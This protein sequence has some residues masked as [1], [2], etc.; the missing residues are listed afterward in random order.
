MGVATAARSP[1]LPVMAP[2]GP[3]ASLSP[4]G[5]GR[6]ARLER[7]RLNH[8][9]L[10]PDPEANWYFITYLAIG[11][12]DGD[13]PVELRAFL[14][15]LINAGDERRLGADQPREFVSDRGEHLARSRPAG[16]QSRYPPQRG[17]LLGQPTQPGRAGWIMA[18]P[19][20]GTAHVGAGIWR[21]HNADGSPVLGGPAMLALAV[22]AF[23]SSASGNSASTDVPAPAGLC[24]DAH[25]GLDRLLSLCST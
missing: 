19:R 12:D 11:P 2:N 18:R 5:P 17:L 9:G 3:L 7:G 8:P 22:T 14:Q 23:S 13:K 1:S 21:V 16:H 24:G 15:R 25:A 6:A 4:L 20:A 10:Q